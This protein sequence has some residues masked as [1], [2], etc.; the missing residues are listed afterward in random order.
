MVDF[1]LEDF[2]RGSVTQDLPWEAVTPGL[3][4]GDLL[5]GK[6][7]NP[8]T[9][10]YEPSDQAVMPLYGSLI[11]GRVGMGIVDKRISHLLKF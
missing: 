2:I 5:A 1:L 8:L 3:H 11:A 6:V 4:I 9:L 7:I 10:W